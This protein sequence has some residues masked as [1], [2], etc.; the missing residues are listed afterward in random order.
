MTG[1]AFMK[2]GRAPTTC[3]TVLLMIPLADGASLSPARAGTHG[4]ISGPP[5]MPDGPSRRL[6]VSARPTSLPG[7]IA[8]TARKPRTALAPRPHP[9]ARR[10]HA[11]LTD[12]LPATRPARLLP[13]PR[14]PART[15]PCGASGDHRIA[16]PMRVI[17]TE[18]I[19]GGRRDRPGRGPRGRRLD[20]APSERLARIALAAGDAAAA[21]RILRRPH[22][23]WSGHMNAGGPARRDRLPARALRRGRR[24]PGTDRRAPAR[25]RTRPTPPG[26]LAGRAGP[27]GPG[28][29]PGPG[30]RRSQRPADRRPGQ[31]PGPPP[32]DQL[33]AVSPGRLH[34]PGP[35]RRAGASRAG[36]GSA[37]GRPGPASRATRASAS[38]PPA[39]IVD[40]V[41]YHRILPDLEPGLPVD[42]HGDRDGT[43]ARAAHRSSSGRRCSSRPRTTSTPRS[44]WPWATC[45]GSRSSTRSAASSRRRGVSRMGD[46]VEG[47]TGTSRPA[48]SR[49]PACAERRGIV[50]LSETMRADILARGGI[51]AGPGDRRPERRRHRRVH[52]RAAR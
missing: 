5:S 35:E 1:A 40:G 16:A 46:A 17:S 9:D 31:G 44:P 48:R 12:A 30:C 43:R 41:E 29:A 13:D 3:A 11:R 15:S 36:P 39:T 8:R 42:V 47:A 33:P 2:L 21:D 50:T 7:I 19:S 22:R 25:R 20:R 51:D 26:P 14:R 23:P 28:L 52:A 32:A 10:R 37:H 45:S 24:A 34:G 18:A 6:R 49:P 27:A 4:R 38:A